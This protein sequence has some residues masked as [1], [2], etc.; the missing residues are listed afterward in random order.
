[1]AYKRS[2]QPVLP[3]EQ[4]RRRNA[5]L[6]RELAELMAENTH[7]EPKVEAM[8]RDVTAARKKLSRQ[9]RDLD[10]IRSQAASIA[11]LA[12]L[13]AAAAPRFG[14]PDGLQAAAHE[15]KAHEDKPLPPITPRR[16]G[17]RGGSHGTR[18]KYEE[19]CDCDDCL[20]WRTSKTKQQRE[21]RQ[22]R[23]AKAAA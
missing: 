17:G 16:L 3:V 23:A 9:I 22:A 12:E 19:G 11:A 20:G 21:L 13:E 18:R 15:I 4:A 5:E 6:R 1:M 2:V 8:R 7:L 14:G 10:A